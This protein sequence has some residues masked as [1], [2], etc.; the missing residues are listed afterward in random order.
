MGCIGIGIDFPPVLFL[1]DGDGSKVFDSFGRG[2]FLH[3][4]HEHL[5]ELGGV[6]RGGLLLIFPGGEMLGHFII[7]GFFYGAHIKIIN[8]IIWMDNRFLVGRNDSVENGGMFTREQIQQ[9]TQ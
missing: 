8:L 4:L 1:L 9:L 2:L 3:E 6:E 5:W 7:K